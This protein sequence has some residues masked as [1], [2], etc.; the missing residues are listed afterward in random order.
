MASLN[1]VMILGNLGKDPELKQ[2]PSG[3]SVANLS[4]ATTRKDASG[5]EETEWH[6]VI[7]W[8]KSADAAAKYLHKGSSCFV[9]GRLRTRKYQKDGK[10]HFATE[11]M[12]DNVQFLS[13]PRR[14]EEKKVEDVDKI[15]DALD[16]LE[17]P[18]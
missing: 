7:V 10:D 3:L 12:A 6:R 5:K 8:G 16:V 2:I 17:I 14:E 13:S 1:R 11:I 18:F 4:V 15:A 9:E